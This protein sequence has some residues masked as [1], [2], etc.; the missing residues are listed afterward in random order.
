MSQNAN[1]LLLFFN[2]PARHKLCLLMLLK[3]KQGDVEQAQAYADRL[4]VPLPEEWGDDWFNESVTADPDFIRMDFD[5]ST[6]SDLPLAYLQSLFEAGLSGA[7]IEVFHDQVGEF[8][9]AHFV[10]GHLVNAEYLCKKIER[11]KTALESQF[12]ADE[13]DVH[14]DD[15]SKPVAIADALKQREKQMEEAQEM[16][17]LFRD[18]GKAAVESGS[19]PVEILESALILRAAGKGLL[20]ALLFGL[21]TI[22]LFKGIWIWIGLTVLLAVLLPLIYVSGVTSDLHGDEDSENTEEHTEENDAD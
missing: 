8:S 2:N 22:L 11:A 9:R 21:V 19:N 13:E 7:A 15:Y 12:D 14:E 4:N 10:K 18:L 5:S 6:T 1:T 20:Q 17:D 3:L 16:V